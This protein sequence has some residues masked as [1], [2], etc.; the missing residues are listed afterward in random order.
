MRWEAYKMKGEINSLTITE[1]LRPS[2]DLLYKKKILKRYI[3]EM[4]ALDEDFYKLVDS[5]I[6]DEEQ[7]G[8]V[9]DSMLEQTQQLKS[10]N[11]RLLEDVDNQIMKLVNNL[12]EQVEDIKQQRMTLTYRDHI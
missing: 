7:K 8:K 1:Q 5:V 3:E 9:I 2:D 12:N 4:V 11:L 6:V 10:E